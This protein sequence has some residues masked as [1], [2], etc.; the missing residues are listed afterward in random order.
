MK[1][2]SGARQPIK[3]GVRRSSNQQRSSVSSTPSGSQS[4]LNLSGSGSVIGPQP[5]VI[6]SSRRLDHAAI[7]E[8]GES[9]IGDQEEEDKCKIVFFISD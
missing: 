9:L 6:G 4:Q 1:R 3:S 7:P 8:D 2:F 5:L